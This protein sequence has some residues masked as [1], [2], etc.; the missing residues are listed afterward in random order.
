MGEWVQIAIGFIGGG[1]FSTL[2][3]W[4]INKKKETVELEEKELDFAEK[5]INFMDKENARYIRIIEES[6]LRIETLEQKVD[7]LI[8][9]KCENLGCT[10]RRPARIVDNEKI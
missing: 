4:R 8:N 6:Y 2:L 5:S 9:Y 7:N 3:N 1:A 10:K